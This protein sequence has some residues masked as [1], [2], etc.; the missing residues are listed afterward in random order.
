RRPGVVRKRI[1][2][3]GRREERRRVIART[4]APRSLLSGLTYARILAAPVVTGLILL[5]PDRASA[6]T[7]AAVVFAV[8]AVTDFVDGYLARL[9]GDGRD[10]RALA[11]SAPSAG[12]LAAAGAERVRGDVSGLVRL[13]S[14]M[15][16][17]GVVYHAGRSNAVCLR[18]PSPMLEITVEGSD[19]VVLA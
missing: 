17:C 12:V 19:A 3:S 10:V 6:Y 4:A 15:A 8:A 13:A 5:G 7:A 14:G 16:G 1:G 2:G 9:F 11:R 18:A